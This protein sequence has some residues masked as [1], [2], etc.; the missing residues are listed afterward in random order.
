MFY[1]EY[2]HSLDSK[3]RVIIPSRYR[4]IFKD[5]YSEN[6]FINKGLD[7]CLFLFTE[8]DWKNQ[9]KKFS[10]HSFTN[11]DSRKFNRL[12]FS[13]AVDVTLDRQGRVLIPGYL[14]KYAEIKQD[15][16]IIGA[17]NRIEIWSK[18]HW[19]KFYESS[20]TDYEEVAERL[21]NKNLSQPT[22][23]DT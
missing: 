22:G 19:E 21:F 11:A 15:V 23:G 9:E 13:G 20:V 14:K 17:S 3:D 2:H 10:N 6:L 18:D 4:E 16:V 7:K 5:N 8:E 12:F 1:G